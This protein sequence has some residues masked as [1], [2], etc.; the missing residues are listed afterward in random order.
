MK[1]IFRCILAVT[2][3]MFTFSAVYAQKDDYKW[4]GFVGY[5]Y[6]NLNRGIDLGRSKQRT[7]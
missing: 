5:T 1:A 2:A 4:E 3:F 6:L 7:Q